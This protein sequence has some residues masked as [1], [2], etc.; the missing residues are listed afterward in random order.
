MIRRRLAVGGPVVLTGT[1]F[2]SD[3][4]S[5]SATLLGTPSYLTVTGTASTPID[6]AWTDKA[7]NTDAF[8]I[9]RRQDAGCTTFGQIA[10]V[11]PSVAT[12]R[13]TGLTAATAYG[14]RDARILL[15]LQQCGGMWLGARIADCRTL[16]PRAI[17]AGRSISSATTAV[18]NTAAATP[19]KP[20]STRT[21]AVLMP[22]TSFDTAVVARRN[23]RVATGPASRVAAGRVSTF[24]GTA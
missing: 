23:L 22:R 6:L 12:Y 17:G 3:T 4:P 7:S 16:L 20:G 8:K 1:T 19:Q 11:G 18:Q 21:S 24:L 14:Y 13:N 15:R 2:V 9:E 5:V 10:T